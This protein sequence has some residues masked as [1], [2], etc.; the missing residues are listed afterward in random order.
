M[1]TERSARL[2]NLSDYGLEVGKSADVT[3]IDARSPVEAV[4]SV[5]PV[6]AVFKNGRQTVSRP[7]AELLR[8][9]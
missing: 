7:R 9:A 3:V 8:P 5:A 4:R 2:L 1:V 6:L